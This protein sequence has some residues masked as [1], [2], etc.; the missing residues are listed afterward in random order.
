MRG[1]VYHNTINTKCNLRENLNIS[2]LFLELAYLPTASAHDKIDKSRYRQA[3]QHKYQRP[4]LQLHAAGG[5][6]QKIVI[7]AEMGRLALLLYVALVSSSAAQTAGNDGQTCGTWTGNYRDCTC[8]TMYRESEELCCN[9]QTCFQPTLKL[10]KLSCPFQ[11]ANGGKYD[12]RLRVCDC[13]E[14]YYGRCC[15]DGK[16]PIIDNIY[17]L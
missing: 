11:C 6:A 2:L 3:Q 8:G 4:I 17:Y 15:E 5:I 1:D 9:D 10:E 13:A 14:G 16:S 12:Q 7:R